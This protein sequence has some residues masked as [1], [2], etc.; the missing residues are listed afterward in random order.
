V[1]QFFF[2]RELTEARLVIRP[3]QPCPSCF[4][5]NFLFISKIP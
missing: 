1:A 2:T 5:P 3:F 4:L